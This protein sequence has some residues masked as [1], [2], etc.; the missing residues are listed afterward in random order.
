MR[1][2]AVIILLWLA[3][4]SIPTSQ[5]E[6]REARVQIG[7]T[8]FFL[9]DADVYGAPIFMPGEPLWLYTLESSRANLI[10]PRGRVAA[11]VIVD[12]RP[13]PIYT[14]GNL[15][16]LGGWTLDVQGQRFSSSYLVQLQKRSLD[17]VELT[18]TFQLENQSLLSTGT[19]RILSDEAIGPHNMVLVRHPPEF[20]LQEIPT[21][22]VG[23]LR[24]QVRLTQAAEQPDRVALE[25]YAPELAQDEEGLASL[26]RPAPTNASAVFWAEASMDLPFYKAQAGR[27]AITIVSGV[28]AKTLP[29]KVLYTDRP[30]DRVELTLP[31][32]SKVGAGG[33]MPL[34]FGKGSIQVYTQTEDNIHITKIPVYFL[35]QGLSVG[36]ADEFSSPPLVSSFNYALRDNVTKA[37][38]YKLYLLSNVNGAQQLW[39]SSAK[40][41]I[42]KITVFNNLTQSPLQ[43]Y[44]TT[45]S[46]RDGGHVTVEGDTYLL[47]SRDQETIQM[48]LH[49]DGVR[50]REEDISPRILTVSPLSSKTVNVAAGRIEFRVKDILGVPLDDG[51]IQ[52]YRRN[53]LTAEFETEVR[54]SQG[55]MP[56]LTM[57]TG[58]YTVNVNSLGATT[59]T[60][61]FV[62]SAEKA[63]DLSVNR[64]QVTMEQAMMSAAVTIIALEVLL[65]YNIWRRLFRLRNALSPPSAPK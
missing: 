28:I 32:L 37:S 8:P 24:L 6:A 27:T 56:T 26:A 2:I 36:I 21:G 43:G 4:V 13:T 16:P 23:G 49:V 3:A 64:L 52:L 50:F 15:D 7:F 65:V 44:R 40:P 20:L 46:G 62:D 45:L 14:F 54:W 12:R 47:L 35:S 29:I 11:S 17:R 9:Y 19:V 18:N 48:D 39:N 34:R 60:L 58:T 51:T 55:A 31:S 1:K 61:F 38:E 59:S 5:A 33:T 41:P 63:V 30:T 25:P 42:A 57:P 10:D 22:N 53:G